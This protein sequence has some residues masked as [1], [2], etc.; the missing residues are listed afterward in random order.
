MASIEVPPL[1]EVLGQIPDVR[2]ARG[3]RH[4]L[5][6][7]LLLACVAM[8][9][10]ARSESAIAEWGANYGPEWRRRLGLTHAR[11]PSQATIHRLFRR[12]DVTR[13]ETCLGQWAQ[14]VLACVPAPAAADGARPLEG[15]ALDGKTL[16]GSRK[17]G[18]VDTHLL[19]AV[20]QRLGVVLGQVAVA[21]KTNEI[22]TA[23][24]LLAQLVLTGRVVT[25]DALLT[26]T[27]LAETILAQGGDYLMVVKDNQPTLAADL[28]TLFADPDA[29]VTQAEETALHGGCCARRRLLASTELAGYVRFPGVAQVLAM[30]RTVV[31]KRTGEV[32][33][34]WAYAVTSLPPARAAPAQL[35]TLWREHWAIENK[36]HYV[37]DVTFD[38]DRASVWKDRI[39][40]VMAALRNATIGLVRLS[41]QTNIAAAC[42][43]F[44]AQPA[45]ALAVVGLSP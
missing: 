33:R 9:G 7:V 4:P 14:Q 21:D 5:R 20:S 24:E 38:E 31:H 22:P 44:A 16:R 36:L 39:P 10:G 13:L 41:G 6:A 11:G 23:P 29:P 8:L 34:E 32:R 40:Q 17:R 1:A 37:R 30:E 18:A 28:A 26:Q 12:I 43:H 42:R 19:S 35:L 2:H 3:K 45:A 15:I 25:V 27:A